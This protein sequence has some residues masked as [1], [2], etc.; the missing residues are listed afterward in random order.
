MKQGNEN[1]DHGVDD[2]SDRATIAEM[3]LRP[4]RRRRSPMSTLSVGAGTTWASMSPSRCSSCS[5]DWQ[6]L[7]SEA[8]S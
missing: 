4:L 1:K 7:V 3:L 6:K 2:C 8:V 5:Q